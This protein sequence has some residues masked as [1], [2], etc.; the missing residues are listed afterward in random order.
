MQCAVVEA[1]QRDLTATRSMSA[2]LEIA[3]AYAS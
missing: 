1:A 2:L 3:T